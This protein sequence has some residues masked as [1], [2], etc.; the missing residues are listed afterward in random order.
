MNLDILQELERE[1]GRE[2]EG[3]AVFAG[4]FGRVEEKEFLDDSCR[5][6]SAVERRSGFE[7]NAQDFAAAEFFE[8]GRQ[9]HSAVLRFR[10]NDFDASILQPACLG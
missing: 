8:D 3:D 10:A 4:D 7:E 2:S 6:S 1:F 5:E 9:I